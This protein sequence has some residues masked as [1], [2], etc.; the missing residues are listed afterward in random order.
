MATKVM[1]FNPSNGLY[2]EGYF[3][4]S[5]TYLFFGWI[6]P[7][8][9]SEL[10][11]AALHLLFTLCTFGIWQL[12]FPFLYNKQYTQRRLQEGF[13]LRDN[14]YVEQKAR[15]AL[16]IIAPAMNTPQ[17]TIPSL[18]TPSVHSETINQSIVSPEISID[19]KKNKI[20]IAIAGI[21]LLVLLISLISF[22]KSSKR[23]DESL[24]ASTQTAQS[25]AQAKA[26]KLKAEIAALPAVTSR[27]LAH[28]YDENT[29]AADQRF[30]GKKF[31]VTGIV[32]DI[33]TD[34]TGSP[35]VT[36]DNSDGF[37][38]PQFELLKSEKKDIAKLKKGQQ[39]SLLCVGRGDIAKIP[40]SDCSIL[41]ETKP[42]STS[43][44]TI[45]NQTVQIPAPQITPGIPDVQKSITSNT[46]QSSNTEAM[47]TQSY[48]VCNLD[49][50][51]DNF[52]ALKDTP[53][54][55]SPTLLKM[56]DGTALSILDKRDSWY[57]VKMTNGKIGWA[58]SK[59]ICQTNG[60]AT[61][62]EA[63]QST[64]ATK[65]SKSASFNC[66]NAS[67]N[68]EKMICGS[69]ELSELDAQLSVVYKNTLSIATE[70]E[71]L[72]IYQ[73]N[74]RKNTRDTCASES[75]VKSAYKNRIAELK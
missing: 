61:Q 65:A 45:Q 73:N 51:G 75:C 6:V 32:T 37:L 53:S 52:L 58:H 71:S 56:T 63:I 3:G 59:W 21:I 34:L 43:P 57:Q 69:E 24:G 39:L 55:S 35:Y 49:P 41:N 20:L 67:T 30:K 10:G 13:I 40:M 48:R 46:I 66:L 1:L 19:S 22:F 33:N 28:A 74:W 31:K 70:K 5:W 38:E 12:I 50:N 15:M 9:R 64:T 25:E 16:S 62:G 17:Q 44:A 14:E 29:V 36:L 4:F 7:I 54:G 23:K 47:N 11:V 72:K 27:D 18:S 2:K 26:D 60:Q 68:I 8:F 42:E